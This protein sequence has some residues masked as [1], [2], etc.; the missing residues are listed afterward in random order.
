MNSL[1]TCWP[2]LTYANIDW[3]REV[4]CELHY[5]RVTYYPFHDRSRIDRLRSIVREVL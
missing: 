4:F 5:G 3:Q 1:F 2:S